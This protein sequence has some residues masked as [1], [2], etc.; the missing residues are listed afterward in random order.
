MTTGVCLCVSVCVRVCAWVH[1]LASP[2]P[3]EGRSQGS[4]SWA[5]GGT[6]A[7]TSAGRARPPVSRPTSPLAAPV[8]RT[9]CCPVCVSSTGRRKAG[10]PC[11]GA[12]RASV[13]ATTCSHRHHMCHRCF[14]QWQATL[15]RSGQNPGREDR[16]GSWCSGTRYDVYH[17]SNSCST[18]DSRPRFSSNSGGRRWPR[19]LSDGWGDHAI[20]S[21]TAGKPPGA[22][23]PHRTRALRGYWG[24][25][26]LVLRLTITFGILFF[27]LH[28]SFISYHLIPFPIKIMQKPGS[29][30]SHK[31]TFCS[32]PPSFCWLWF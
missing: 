5:G 14:F 32:L 17:P 15:S 13:S 7:E 26:R 22:S 31:N 3:M 29:L 8:A 18:G 11:R 12:E 24:P 30:H 9:G 6:A 10:L 2:C 19:S 20:S 21:E 27:F 25:H 1:P 23:I 4:I 28:F 16:G